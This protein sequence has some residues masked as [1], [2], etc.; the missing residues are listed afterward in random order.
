MYRSIWCNHCNII[1]HLRPTLSKVL[2]GQSVGRGLRC[3]KD[4]SKCIIVDVSSNW[5]TFGPVEDLK[6]DL[7]SHRRSF[8]KFQNRINWIATQFDEAEN[9]SSFFVHITSSWIQCDIDDTNLLISHLRKFI[10][11][12]AIR[13]RREMCTLD[14]QGLVLLK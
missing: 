8:I 3:A 6:W 12:R 4:K 13:C 11:R 10:W 9:K 2:W 5:S 7:W 1:V 14:R